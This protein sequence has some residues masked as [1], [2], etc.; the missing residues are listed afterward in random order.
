MILFLGISFEDFVFLL[1]FSLLIL[2]PVALLCWLI[3]SVIR[4]LNRH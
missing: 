3:I 2:F 4:Y 1:I